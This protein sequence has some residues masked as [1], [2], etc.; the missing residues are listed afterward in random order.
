MTF[1][2]AQ[3]PGAVGKAKVRT[4]K[5][6]DAGTYEAATCATIAVGAKLTTTRGEPPNRTSGVLATA[7]FFPEMKRFSPSKSTELI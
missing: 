2:D 3:I 4:Y 7:K 5:G 6:Y 1:S